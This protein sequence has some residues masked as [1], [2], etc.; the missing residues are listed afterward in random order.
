MDH[1]LTRFDWVKIRALFE[2]GN[3]I[4]A[5]AKMPEMPSKQAISQRAHKE[6]WERVG[7]LD[8]SI[9]STALVAA[10]SYLDDRQKFVIQEIA[11]GSTQRLAANLAGCHETT[12][13]DW[14]LNPKFSMALIAAKAAKVGVRLRKIH[15]SEDWR[16]AGWLMERDP[17]SRD[18]FMPPNSSRGMTGT[19]FNALGHVNVGFERAEEQREIPVLRSEV[20][21]S[22]G[23]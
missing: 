2:A 5:I 15:Q 9:E 23:H 4:T 3:G 14:K 13:S 17:D 22:T 19:T 11:N 21:P 18:E 6:G 7:Q 10:M 1:P 20:I 12:I 16:A 8:Q